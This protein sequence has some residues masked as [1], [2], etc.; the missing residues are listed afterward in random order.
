MR[1]QLFFIIIFHFF[2]LTHQPYNGLNRILI[3]D[4]A[5]ID[6]ENPHKIYVPG[7]FITSGPDLHWFGYY[8][9]LQFDPTG[10]YLLA[11]KTGFENKSPQAEDKI[12]IGMIDLDQG[13]KWIELGTSKAWNW[14]QGCMLQF[15]PGSNSEVIWN[16][17]IGDQF[18]CHIIDIHSGEMRTLPFPVYTLSPD[19]KKALSVDF[20]RINDLRPGYGYAGIPDPNSH[21]TAPE[22]AGIYLCD[23]EK[24]SKKLIISISEMQQREITGNDPSFEDMDLHM[25]WFNHLLFNTDGSRFVFLHRWKSSLKKSVGG[26]GTLM[27]SARPDGSDIRIVDGSGYTSHFIWKNPEQLL[28]WTYHPSHEFGFYLFNDNGK[29]DPQIIGRNS[30]IR[31]GHCTYLPDQSWI[32][33]DTYPDSDRMQHVYL[34]HTKDNRRIPIGDFFLPDV[35]RGEWRVDTHPR[36]SPDGK[37]VIIDAVDTQSGRQL[38]LMDISGI[39]K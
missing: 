18:V 36:S 25:N 31:N 6:R 32:L 4:K 16:N 17:R 5:A 12:K 24:G 27:Y 8:D 23:L 39:I 37:T 3:P 29:Q 21:L 34:Y 2:N 11:M 19:G 33:N 38:Y 10:R 15:I 7:R 35:Y 26:F 28:I 13:D 30:M 20:E 1:L 22:N 9:K 14:Q